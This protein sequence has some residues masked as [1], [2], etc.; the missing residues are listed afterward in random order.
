MIEFLTAKDGSPTLRFSNIL[1]HSL[2]SPKKEADKF[3]D[4]FDLEE[5]QT[6][7][8]CGE[9]LGYLHNA[10]KR[11]FPGLRI[12]TVFYHSIFLDHFQ[13]EESTFWSPG[14]GITLINFL[15]N[16]LTLLDTIGIEVIRWNASEHA[17]PDVSSSLNG[18]INQLFLEA[19]G[20]MNTSKQFGKKW[21]SNS[22]VNFQK[23]N[24]L[25]S[26]PSIPDNPVF[27]AASGPSLSKSFRLMKKIRSR[28]NIWALSSS[29][30]A[31]ITEGI[32]PDMIIQTDPG[33][34]ASHHLR[35]LSK[36]EIPLAM[37]F[38]AC[39]GL[40]KYNSI[41]YPFSQE[42]FFDKSIY[43]FTGQKVP[44]IPQAGTVAI[45][46]LLLAM[47]TIKTA[48]I[49][50]TGWDF[51]HSDIITHVR[52]HSFMP[53]FQ[54][55]TSRHIPL[56][57]F[58]YNR[59]SDSLSGVSGKK[60][61]NPNQPLALKTYSGWIARYS[62]N[63][64]NRVFRLY[65][66]HVYLGKIEDKSEPET[67]AMCSSFPIIERRDYGIP[68]FTDISYRNKILKRIFKV[69][70]EKVSIIEKTAVLGKSTFFAQ[71]VLTEIGLSTSPA[72]LLKL[73]KNSASLS[74]EDF[75]TS[76]LSFTDKMRDVIT[77]WAKELG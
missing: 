1:V 58:L 46:A 16:E 37:P 14:S 44:V 15:Q 43:P 13:P 36:V 53:L 21:L 68:I 48:P 75:S 74:D 63:L 31:L 23:L 59:V 38:S 20:S 25:Y 61:K 71:P 66:S 56:L 9:T 57:T 12:I 4:S 77:A 69:W 26:F 7:I 50:L 29:L 49:F 54:A 39:R 19:N 70:L 55:A 40:W 72:D 33:Y 10:L 62:H 34:Y 30:T 45:S 32:I 42:G 60:T 6:V 76:V 73:K 47:K 5:K 2:Y 41:I 52:P 18:E 35:I 28:I 24:K 17:F 22:I 11:R 27:I 3:I 8:L 67:E 64:E 65:P 51:C